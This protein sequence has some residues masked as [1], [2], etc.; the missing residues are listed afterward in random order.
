MLTKNMGKV[1]RS[2]RITFAA[3]VGA[4]FLA[5]KISGITAIVLGILAVAFFIT[6]FVGF[7][8]LY[9]LVGLSTSKQQHE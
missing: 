4:L 9:I 5:G 8:P 3:V 2:I 1:D 6:S 7:C